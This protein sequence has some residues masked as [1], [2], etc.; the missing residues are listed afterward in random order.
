MPFGRVGHLGDQIFHAP[1][2]NPWH[3]A[4]ELST[5]SVTYPLCGSALINIRDNQS[6]MRPI[7]TYGLWPILVLSI[8]HN[9]KG[10]AYYPNGIHKVSTPDGR[11]SCL[12][13]SLT[14]SSKC[15]Q[16]TYIPSYFLL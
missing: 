12:I 16:E 5:Y 15:L 13:Y 2:A 6:E 3:Y 11:A 7:K 8:I 9:L 10:P 14:D 4:A 1:G